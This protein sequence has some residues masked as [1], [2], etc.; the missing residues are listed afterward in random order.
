MF[1]H[2]IKFAKEMGDGLPITF[3]GY[4]DDIFIVPGIWSCDDEKY[5]ILKLI[6][7]FFAM[8]RVD[9]YVVIYDV[10]YNAKAAV[11]FVKINREK[12][13]LKL[14][15]KEDWKEIEHETTDV[16]GAFTELLA[17]KDLQIPSDLQKR[18]SDALDWRKL[19]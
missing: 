2:A 10:T 9:E 15:G 7:L 6:T 12:R 18:I 17:P 4:S 13:E 3:I 16:K 5:N 19:T 14:F 8:N 11:A 1:E